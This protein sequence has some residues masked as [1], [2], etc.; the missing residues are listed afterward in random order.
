MTGEAL[1]RELALQVETGRM[2]PADA[3][4]ARQALAA[5]PAA[6]PAPADPRDSQRIRKAGRRTT[7]TVLDAHRRRP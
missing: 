1:E 5:E 6:A 7:A 2:D 4:A 3:E